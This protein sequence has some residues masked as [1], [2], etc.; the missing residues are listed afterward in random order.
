MKD[1]ENLKG[2]WFCTFK[3][4]QFSS[5]VKLHECGAAFLTFGELIAH[6]HSCHDI[7]RHWL[8]DKMR[9]AA[10]QPGVVNGQ[11]QLG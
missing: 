9:N 5:G 1:N 11:T 8:N 10:H 7:N 6:Y 3:V 2:N 4:G